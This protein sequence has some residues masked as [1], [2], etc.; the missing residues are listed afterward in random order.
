MLLKNPDANTFIRLREEEK[1]TIKVG[2]LPCPDKT[3]ALI[4]EQT[5]ELY[6]AYE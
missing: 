2:R 3:T 6:M 1:T 4:V 5:F